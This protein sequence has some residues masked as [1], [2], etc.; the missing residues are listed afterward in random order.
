MRSRWKVKVPSSHQRCHCHQCQ[1]KVNYKTNKIVTFPFANQYFQFL[2]FFFNHSH[3]PRVIVSVSVFIVFV[4]YFFG[5]FFFSYEYVHFILSIFN[6]V[7]PG[8]YW[9]WM[10]KPLVAVVALSLQLGWRTIMTSVYVYRALLIQCSVAVAL[11]LPCHCR[12]EF[13][14]KPALIF[15]SHR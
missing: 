14:P 12:L 3:I 7:L 2:F 6:S 13:L 10:F 15:V 5:R 9:R 1:W 8:L 4:H 11:L